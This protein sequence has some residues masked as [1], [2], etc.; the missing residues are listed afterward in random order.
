MYRPDTVS[1]VPYSLH[2]GVHSDHQGPTLAHDIGDLSF[3]YLQSLN[4]RLDLGLQEHLISFGQF[5]KSRFLSNKLGQVRVHIGDDNLLLYLSDSL[6]LFRHRICEVSSNNKEVAAGKSGRLHGL[7]SRTNDGVFLL[8]R[9]FLDQGHIREQ[10]K[11]EA[12]LVPPAVLDDLVTIHDTHQA[13][14]H[15]A[16]AVSLAA[17]APVGCVLARCDVFRGARY[18]EAGFARFLPN[19]HIASF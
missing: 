13:Q 12:Y 2:G 17:L 9:R 15:V 19:Y 8:Y 7:L 5:G 4:H 1:T 3:H 6:L 18:R 14:P 11:R 10:S 16:Y